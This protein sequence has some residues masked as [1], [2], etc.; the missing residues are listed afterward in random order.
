MLGVEDERDM[1]HPPL[2]LARC[3]LV[4]QRQKVATDTLLVAVEGDANALVTELVP[5]DQNARKGGQQPIRH[6]MLMFETIFRL[7]IAK[8]GAA[9][10]QHIHG[11]GIGGNPLQHFQQ[12]LGQAAQAAQLALV[13]VKLLL[14]GQLPLSSR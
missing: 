7:Q 4:Q 1:H 3:L 5:V 14:T 9:G 8:H 6:F 10:A 11:M 13:G 2:Q 12:R